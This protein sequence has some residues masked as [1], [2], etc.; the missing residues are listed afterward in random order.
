MRDDA[1]RKGKVGGPDFTFVLGL[2]R[3]C[4]H[5]RQVKAI[6]FDIWS[7]VSG[8]TGVHV[9]PCFFMEQMLIKAGKGPTAE[10]SPVS[11]TNQS[12]PNTQWLLGQLANLDT[13]SNLKLLST[14]LVDQSDE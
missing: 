14:L 11:S 9:N 2:S 7:F 8:H 12:H 1:R 5:L 10:D 13:Q 3:R 6:D 4:A